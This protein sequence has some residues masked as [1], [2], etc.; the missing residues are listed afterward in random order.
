VPLRNFAAMAFFFL[1]F[2]FY[3]DDNAWYYPTHV[4]VPYEQPAFGEPGIYPGI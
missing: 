3:I 4:A 2:R 1:L